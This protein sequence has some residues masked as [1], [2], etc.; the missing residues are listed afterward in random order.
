MQIQVNLEL[1][2]IALA[3][4]AALALWFARR[5]LL[6]MQ[7]STDKQ[8]ESARQLELQTRANIL[9]TLDQ[10]WEGAPLSN[11]RRELQVLI[12]EAEAAIPGSPS[13]DSLHLLRAPVLTTKLEAMRKADFPKYFRL[14]KICGFFET[15]GLVART[16][17]V[18]IGDV[19]NLL[20]G[21]VLE[22]GRA[23]RP[24]I[25]SIHHQPGADPKMFE[26]FLWLLS[27][28]EKRLAIDLG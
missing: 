13:P 26:H 14:Y 25:N 7:A 19:L 1:T 8:A 21:S 22:A 11:I 12:A 28:L 15:V 6:E 9:L 17:Y 27:E 10:R 16:G 23:F 4:V 20:G 3:V 18:P 24:H 5:Q 2:G